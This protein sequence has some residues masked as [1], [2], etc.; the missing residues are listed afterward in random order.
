M[1]NEIIQETHL[2]NVYKI[3][4]ETN[5]NGYSYAYIL[6]GKVVLKAMYID[7]LMRKALKSRLRLRWINKTKIKRE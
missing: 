3:K 5:R 4:D 2:Q 1:E 6:D 7:S